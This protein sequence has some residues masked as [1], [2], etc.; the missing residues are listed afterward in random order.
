VPELS[1]SQDLS[2]SQGFACPRCKTIMGEV[3]RIAPLTDEAGLI[4]YECP[5]C[6]YVTSVLLQPK[7]PRR[8]PLD[9][10]LHN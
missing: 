4:G 3:V 7:Q 10:R 2:K 9:E 8:R 6:C 1:K 5:A